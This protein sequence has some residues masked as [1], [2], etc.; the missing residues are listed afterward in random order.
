[1][2]RD[3]LERERAVPPRHQASP[4]TSTAADRVL[5]LQRSAGNAAV[6]GLIG[7][8]VQ[9]GVGEAIEQVIGV[10]PLDT[11]TARDD[12][13]EAREAA[14]SSGLRG[15]IDGP[16]DAFRHALWNC[17]MT[18]SIG[19]AQAREV[20]TT[21]EDQADTHPNVTAMDEHNNAWGRILAKQTKDRSQCRQLVMG[22]LRSGDLLI[23]KNW[24]E[25]GEARRA[26]QQLPS[27]GPLVVSNTV[28]DDVETGIR[29]LE[30]GTL[31]V[32]ALNEKWRQK[33]EQK[34]IAVLK[35]PVRHGDDAGAQAKRTEVV[36]LFR[37]F[38]G[39]WSGTYRDRILA[40][41]K[42][43]ELAQLLITRVSRHTRDDVLEVLTGVR[44]RRGR[45]R[46]K[47]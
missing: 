45:D 46:A 7:V 27:Y 25:R 19:A 2:S 20:A 23:I 24:R 35:R 34:I 42:D 41:S 1:V 43:D 44:P 15:Y 32:A 13:I 18:L 5:A 11:L 31:D 10:G 30:A 4:P 12:A 6:S 29:P 9:R 38:A 39:Y 33:H 21:H 40:S 26:K 47:R 36:A 8:P 3:R 14:E 22:A 16:Q 37:D 17:L 28:P